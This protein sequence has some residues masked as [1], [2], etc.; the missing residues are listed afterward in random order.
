MIHVRMRDE[1]VLLLLLL[2]SI[3]ACVRNVMNT[4]D[5]ISP[6]VRETS[7]TLK[8]GVWGATWRLYPRHAA[9]LAFIPCSMTGRPLMYSAMKLDSPPS[10]QINRKAC[11]ETLFVES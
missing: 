11:M 10:I 5:R 8:R 7:K 9:T 4:Y 3:H 1:D 2:E 6:G